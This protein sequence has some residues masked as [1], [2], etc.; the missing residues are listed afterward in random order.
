MKKFLPALILA[1]LVIPVMAMAQ[2]E[3][4]ELIATGQELVE[5]IETIGNWI[6][7]VL[8]VVAAVFLIVAGFMFVTAGGNP[9][10]VTKARQMLINALIG[11]AIA[12]LAKGLVL[13]VGNI[14]GY[15]T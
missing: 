6:F 13:L 2:E 15:T 3:A 14:L 12:L 4:P 7:T 1:S 8:L 5:L 10:A 11:V 9:E